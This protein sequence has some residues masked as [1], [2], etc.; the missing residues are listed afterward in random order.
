MNASCDCISRP[1]DDG[2]DEWTCPVCGL[3]WERREEQL[4]PELLETWYQPR[5]DDA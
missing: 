4:T 3:V 1:I 5:E 2:P